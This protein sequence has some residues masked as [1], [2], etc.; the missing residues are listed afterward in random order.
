MKKISTVAIER[1][2]I[3]KENERKQLFIEAFVY[4]HLIDPATY[5]QQ[6]D[7]LNEEIALAEINERD[8]RIEQMDIQAAVG[9]GEFVLLNAPMGAIVA[10][11][12]TAIATSNLSAGIAVWRRRLSNR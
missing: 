8:A 2:Q 12:E 9:F 4:K 1:I 11:A 10:G 7:K 3:F 5:Q 6:L